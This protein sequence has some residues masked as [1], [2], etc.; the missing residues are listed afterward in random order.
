MLANISYKGVSAKMP[1]RYTNNLKQ[2]DTYI[3]KI[4]NQIEDD[5]IKKLFCYI[6]EEKKQRILR[7]HRFEDAQRTLLGDILARYAIC[8]RTGVQNKDLLFDTNEFGKPILISPNGIHF[9]ISHSGDYVVCVTDEKAVG[10]DIEVIKPIDFNIA[11][12]FFSED[13]YLSLINQ[14]K[15]LQTRYFYMIWTLKESYIK[16]EGKGLNIPLDS[17][18]IKPENLKLNTIL[19]EY[20]EKEMEYHFHQFFLSDDTI[21]AICT[22]NNDSFCKATIFDAEDFIPR[23]VSIL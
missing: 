6:S 1:S 23:A 9:N 2:L 14:P 17:F 8:I 16:A 3:L 21:Y 4:N 22:Q 18:E 12:R 19:K 13:E 15:E 11:E 7:F 5:K 20:K 10:I